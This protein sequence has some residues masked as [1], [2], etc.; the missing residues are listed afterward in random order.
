MGRTRREQIRQ[1]PALRLAG[2]RCAFCKATG[3]GFERNARDSDPAGH[4]GRR[5][6]K[7]ERPSGWRTCNPYLQRKAHSYQC[8][9]S[10]ARFGR[11][12]ASVTK[13][14][15]Q[16]HDGR[17]TCDGLPCRSNDFGYGIHACIPYGACAGRHA[18]FY[19]SVFV[20]AHSASPDR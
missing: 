11:L 3:R 14:H 12:S 20:S 2:L 17:W 1:Y 15:R 4:D 6:S 7:K 19:L 13:E 16:R 8:K 9:G 5:P 18:W 10:R